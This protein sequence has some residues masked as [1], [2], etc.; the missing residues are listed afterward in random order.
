M[1][2][3]D[4]DAIKARL[5]ELELK[6]N[7][8]ENRRVR[9][10]SEEQD[11]R[12]P[13]LDDLSEEGKPYKRLS[14]LVNDFTGCYLI[15]FSGFSLRNGLY[16]ILVALF[17]YNFEFPTI[18]YKIKDKI[19]PLVAD[20]D[21]IE[22]TRTQTNWMSGAESTL[23]SRLLDDVLL[24]LG[25][26][27]RN[28][29]SSALPRIVAF[30]SRC[31]HFGGPALA[32]SPD[33]A[34]VLAKE[35][36]D[37]VKIVN[38]ELR[39][40]SQDELVGVFPSRPVHDDEDEEEE[41]DA[42]QFSDNT[43]PEDATRKS[44]DFAEEQ[45][46]KEF[47]DV[48]PKDGIV[49]RHPLKYLSDH[50]RSIA[51]E[52]ERGQ[53]SV[54]NRWIK[55][56]TKTLARVLESDFD[57]T[58]ENYEYEDA[59]EDDEGRERVRLTH[60]TCWE[61][62]TESRFKKLIVE[63]LKRYLSAGAMVARIVNSPSLRDWSRMLTLMGKHDGRF[64]GF[65]LD[66][67]KTRKDLRE[68]IATLER[69]R[70][71]IFG[72]VKAAGG[73]KPLVKDEDTSVKIGPYASKFVLVCDPG[74]GV[75]KVKDEKGVET[76]YRLSV[77]AK[78]V[79]ETLRLLVGTK[80]ADGFVKLPKKWDA[81]FKANIGSTSQIDPNNDINIV[82]WYIFRE[83]AKKGRGSTGRFRLMPTPEDSKIKELLKL[84]KRTKMLPAK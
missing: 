35:L 75:L 28:I 68:F 50:V 29:K 12:L 74:K 53:P 49:G 9:I 42:D 22:K 40:M 4:L 79:W 2:D 59:P 55:L 41:F 48:L 25:K 52:M 47:A 23:F 18:K 78:K 69:A 33:E 13:I 27:A 5:T 3:A 71:H 76:E 11:E 58:Y 62:T 39:L 16:E 6:L 57:L 14:W 81:R 1:A 7:S 34:E 36:L 70:D 72:D 77:T 45:H 32:N 80:A 73:V 31:E 20:E 43:D 65:F 61:E 37:C 17:Q 15:Q 30:M 26:L 56:D 54:D 82:R 21:N 60:D 67:S 63:D 51:D 38:A 66:E 84:R 8:E 64:Y 83:N 24:S 44:R 46:K 10:L 19:D